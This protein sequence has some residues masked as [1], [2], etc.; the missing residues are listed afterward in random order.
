MI[1]A[2]S[3][4]IQE[5]GRFTKKEIDQGQAG[6]A[7]HC[8]QVESGTRG[9]VHTLPQRETAPRGMQG[10]R[11]LPGTAGSAGQ[12]LNRRGGV[13]FYPTRVSGP[14]LFPARVS[15]I[16]WRKCSGPTSKSTWYRRAHR[17][18]RQIASQVFGVGIFGHF[19]SGF[20]FF[21]LQ[22][23]DNITKILRIETPVSV[24]SSRR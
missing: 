12:V 10:M 3:G 21:P 23:F 4:G 24:C 16:L 18:Q 5:Y 9:G 15:R 14:G 13:P 11:L 7:A 6:P 2:D 17:V 19:V 22:K 1:R 20:G 8:L